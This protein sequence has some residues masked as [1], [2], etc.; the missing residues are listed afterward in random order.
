MNFVYR[1]TLDQIVR[2]QLGPIH[3][4]VNPGSTVEIPEKYDYAIEAMGVRL[5]KDYEL[6][7]QNDA[8][9]NPERW[10][11]FLEPAEN[12][13]ILPQDEFLTEPQKQ[14]EKIQKQR[15]IRARK[16]TKH[17]DAKHS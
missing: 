5:E 4:S 12:V 10:D 13:D 7:I 11:S 8:D 6:S 9:R 15:A 17:S 16:N 2:F 14:F 3:Y 1:N